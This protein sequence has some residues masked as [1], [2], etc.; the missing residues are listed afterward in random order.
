M[1]KYLV[2]KGSVAVD[3]VSL[4][5]AAVD[6]T[7]FQIALIPTTLSITTLGDRSP[8]WAFNLEA[9]QMAKTIVTTVEAVLARR[10][11]GT[12]AT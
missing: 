8:G 3:G 6:G 10:G 9:D 4:T 7:S 2:P 11:L 12:N 5:I 1:A